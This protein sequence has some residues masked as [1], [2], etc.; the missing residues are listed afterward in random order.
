V[1]P[2]LPVSADY[3]TRN[4]ASQAGEPASL[5]NLYRKLLWMRR[6]SPAL[7]GGHY[8]PLDA[9][10]DCFVYLRAAES[11]RRLVT[12]N[13]S[14][15][16]RKLQLSLQEKGELLLSTYLDREGSARLAELALRPYE[17]V[18]VALSPR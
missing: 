7:Y 2:W 6:H 4:V 12:L 11:E 14:S 13:F 18:I 8:Q 5:L 10:A 17:G 15:Q 9:A 3:K 16:P 1:E